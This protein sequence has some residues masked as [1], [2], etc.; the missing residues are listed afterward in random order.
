[1]PLDLTSAQFC[2]YFD[3]ARPAS[4]LLSSC[5]SLYSGGNKRHGHY[6]NLLFIY[7]FIIYLL[8]IYLFIYFCRESGH[9]FVF[10][11]NQN[12]THLNI[13]I[14]LIALGWQIWISYLV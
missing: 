14:S 8:F 12:E 5:L 9:R 7:L 13:I 6:F 11:E 1:L 2:P 10:S 4:S 3:V